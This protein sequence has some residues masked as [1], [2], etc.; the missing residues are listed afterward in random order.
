MFT[1]L[2]QLFHYFNGFLLGQEQILLGGSRA[3]VAVWGPL[4]TCTGMAIAYCGMLSKVQDL[5]N[6]EA[7]V[8]F[9]QAIAFLSSRKRGE[10]RFKDFAPCLRGRSILVPTGGG[11]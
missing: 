4:T 7:P 6:Q 8:V 1:W 3:F 2:G 9:Q 5:A 11:Q 10:W